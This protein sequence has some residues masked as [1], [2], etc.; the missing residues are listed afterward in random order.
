M[1]EEFQS[2]SSSYLLPAAF[3]VGER[4][5]GFRESD[6]GGRLGGFASWK[7]WVWVITL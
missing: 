5:P 7:F 4:V 1:S 6:V 2:F 3:L